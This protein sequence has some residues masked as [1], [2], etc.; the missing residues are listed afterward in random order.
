MTRPFSLSRHLQTTWT[1]VAE[2]TLVRRSVVSVL[3][4]FVLVWAVLLAYIFVTYKHAIANDP[5]LQKY[6]DALLVSLHNI[7]DPGQAAAAIASTEAWTYI[8]RRQG[9][10]FP[11]KTLHALSDAAG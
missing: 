8:R 11:G 10:V 2:P 9:G 4:A 5:G 3:L 6:G 1:K 7:A